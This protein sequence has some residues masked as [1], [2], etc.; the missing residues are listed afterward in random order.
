[1]LTIR[2]YT[3]TLQILFLILYLS[4]QNDAHAEVKQGNEKWVYHLNTSIPWRNYNNATFNEA[5]S[6]NKPLYVFVYSDECSWCRKFEV[7]TLE[8]PQIRKLIE[9]EFLPVAI[10]QLQQPDLA[11]R[12]G[13]R[14]VP[15]NVLITPDGKR[16]LRF[17]GFLKVDAL[18]NAL[19]NTLNKW[20]S[21]EITDDEFADES[22]C[23]L[24]PDT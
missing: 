19:Q 24:I 1:M 15:G 20:R 4:I 3:A 10:N 8:R 22:T 2:L 13:I 9:K 21:G 7:E 17:Y 6:H 12:L 5:V 23:C 14:L 16:L 11:K 18:T